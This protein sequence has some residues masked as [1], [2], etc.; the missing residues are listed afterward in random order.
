MITLLSEKWPA[1]FAVPDQPIALGSAE[2][3]AKLLNLPM[4][5]VVA[6]IK[7]HCASHAYI[8]AIAAGK[9]RLS[10]NGEVSEVKKAHQE[11]AQQFKAAGY[12]AIS[13]TAKRKA[14]RR[15]KNAAI[16]V[17]LK[18][19]TTPKPVVSVVVKKRRSVVLP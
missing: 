6:A 4:E 12:R 19:P 17:D 10:I 1:L 15:R 2:Q 8:S 16:G 7:G 18:M 3:I 13:K 9:P 11:H 5:D 14:S